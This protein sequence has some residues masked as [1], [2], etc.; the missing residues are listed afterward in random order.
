MAT[1]QLYCLRHW[2]LQWTASVSMQ[3]FRNILTP[4]KK[5]CNHETKFVMKRQ[6]NFEHFFLLRCD[7]QLIFILHTHQHE[8]WEL[9]KRFVNDSQTVLAQG[10]SFRF[11]CEYVQQLVA[12]LKS[13]HIFKNRFTTIDWLRKVLQNNWMLIKSVQMQ[14]KP[15][16]LKFRLFRFYYRLSWFGSCPF[17]F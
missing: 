2:Q 9:G 6:I 3:V 14:N 5:T 8:N 16:Q 10:K 7:I 17:V 13:C 4:T 12:K 1:W 15:Q 11:E